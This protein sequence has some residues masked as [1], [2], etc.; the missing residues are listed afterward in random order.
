MTVE[1]K[2]MMQIGT[3]K[4]YGVACSGMKVGYMVSE[5]RPGSLASR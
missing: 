5:E 4:Y 1:L 3:S 2:H